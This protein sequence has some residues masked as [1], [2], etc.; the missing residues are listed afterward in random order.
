MELALER[1]DTMLNVEKFSHKVPIRFIGTMPMSAADWH[2]VEDNPRQRDTARRA[3]RANHLMTPHPSHVIVHMARL[4]DGR[5]Y[6][7]DGHTRDYIWAKGDVE[8]PHELVVNIWDCGTLDQVKDLYSTFD[9]QGA[10]ENVSDRM[11]GGMNE[12]GL[13]F[14]SPLLRS[15]KFATALRY[16]ATFMYGQEQARAMSV[17][18]MLDYW[19]PELMLLDQCAPS[20]DRFNSGVV[21]GSLLVF[22]RYGERALEFF[23]NYS[24]GKGSKVSGEA[25]AVQAL[26]E[27]ITRLKSARQ[28]SGAS[29]ATL[30]VGL[31]LSAFDAFQNDRTYFIARGGGV[32][33]SK[34]TNIR[35]FATRAKAT[36]RTW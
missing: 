24:Q 17:Y 29:N 36:K 13:N 10:V 21:A 19:S 28:I 31:V 27:R 30:I 16:A 9:N 14:E 32:K 22:R 12:H 7:L 25:D 34:L 18:D 3:K 2:E 15:H 20:P 11:H 35:K 23:E 33:P 1:T 4:P 8:A 5:R 26:E 6:K